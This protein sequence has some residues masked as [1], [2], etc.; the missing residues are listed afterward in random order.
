[1]D[2][3]TKM[4]WQDMI[5]ERPLDEKEIADGLARSF[6]LDPCEVFVSRNPDDFTN[7]SDAKVVCIASARNEG[8]R[9]ILSVYSYFNASSL[10]DMVVVNEF[11]RTCDTSLLIS[12]DSLDPYT[13]TCVLKTGDMVSVN[14]D[15]DLLD[16]MGEYHI[17]GNF[18]QGVAVH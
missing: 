5:A 13:M 8:F 6:M 9:C 18:G 11:A 1:M 16:D 12:N 4:K 2:G 7:P 10:D 15:V 14:L 3:R 17:R